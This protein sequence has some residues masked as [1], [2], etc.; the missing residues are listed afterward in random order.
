MSIVQQDP[1]DMEIEKF[2]VLPPHREDGEKHWNSTH[3]ALIEDAK[4]MNGCQII[5][6]KTVYAH[7]SKKFYSLFTNIFSLILSNLLSEPTSF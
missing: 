6:Q 5:E 7:D 4:R 1:S 2:C 3:R